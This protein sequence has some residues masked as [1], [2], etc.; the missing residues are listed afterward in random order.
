VLENW[1]A[2]HHL[3][4]EPR[5]H[6]ER[7]AG[8]E[9]AASPAVRRALRVGPEAPVRY[10]HVRL[11]CGTVVMS[12]ADH[13]YVPERL[14]PAMNATLDATD[15]PF[16]RVVQPLGFSRVRLSADRP[17]SQ[18]GVVLVHRALLA[19]PDGTPFSYVVESYQRAALGLP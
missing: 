3:A 8:A 16:G 2:S 14:T 5:I 1:C 4:A 12:E 15:E 11:R 10:R 19:L 13:W 6:A 9:P 17:R 7:V 18:P